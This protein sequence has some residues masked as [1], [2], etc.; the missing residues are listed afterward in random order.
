MA[1]KSFFFGILPIIVIFVSS[2]HYETVFGD[3][4]DTSTYD[5]SLMNDE[6]F[7]ILEEAESRLQISEC[8]GIYSTTVT[9]GASVN[10]SEA[11]FCSIKS[12]YEH[13][14]Q[15]QLYRIPLTKSRSESQSVQ[16]NCVPIAIA[17]M[18]KDAPSYED[19]CA[20]CT[21]QYSNWQSEGGVPSNY[22]NRIISHFTDVTTV[23]T[24]N[25]TSNTQLNKCVMLIPKGGNQDHAVNAERYSSANNIIYYHDYWADYWGY[26][27]NSGSIS[28]SRI[29]ALFPFSESDE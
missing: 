4:L 11:L 15:L 20:E 21:S 1:H 23:L 22:V 17:H 26:D 29:T 25:Y 7:K 12:R 13:T 5:V 16:P 9:C 10:I 24:V 14:N 18:G 2:C 8:D 27:S 3:F 19:A 28:A 6:D